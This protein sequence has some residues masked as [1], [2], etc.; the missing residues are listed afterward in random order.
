MD[1]HNEDKPVVSQPRHK[2]CARHIL[3]I[4]LVVF[5]ILLGYM[6]YV[7]LNKRQCVEIPVD[8]ARLM[9]ELTPFNGEEFFRVQ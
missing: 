8:M 5:A 2:F 9:S 1:S 7:K 3:L 6:I 4:I